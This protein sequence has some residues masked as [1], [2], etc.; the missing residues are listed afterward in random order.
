M[1]LTMIDKTTGRDLGV[2]RRSIFNPDRHDLLVY[3][4]VENTSVNVSRC[5]CFSDV[6]N[7]LDA[8]LEFMAACHTVSD[9]TSRCTLYEF[10]QACAHDE[11]LYASDFAEENDFYNASSLAEW[12]Q[13]LCEDIGVIPDSLPWYISDH[14]DWNGV[15]EELLMDYSAVRMDNGEY[16]IWRK[17]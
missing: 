1:R 8:A 4:E 11:T 12:A 10:M 17:M 16:I 6:D 3:S 14:I 9:S 13:D 2:F 7:L 15:A 5:T